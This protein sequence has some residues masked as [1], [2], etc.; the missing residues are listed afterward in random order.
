MPA[1][2]AIAAHPDDIEFVMAGTLLCLRK[3]GW[4]IHYFNISNGDLGS[5]ELKPPLTAKV[6]AAEARAAARIL[7]A[8][9]YPPICRDLSI[10]YTEEN[11]RR[12][13]SVIRTARPAIILTHALS[14]YME[15]HM[16][17][18]RLTV[19]AAFARGIPHY[20][21]KPAR[22]PVL[23]PCVVYHAMPHGQQTPM[24][25]PVR[26]ELYVNTTAVHA[27]KREALLCHQSQRQ[28]LIETQSMQDY[29]STMEQFSR[30]LGNATKRFTHA[31]GWRRHLHYGFARENDD[32]LRTALGD[33][34]IPA[35]SL[36]RSRP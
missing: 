9:W 15:D 27:T 23:D 17:A 26:P 13:C 32:P 12:V 28:W 14:D 5:T 11:L 36:R 21:S 6:R 34:C 8:K 22:Q 35:A 2:L 20:R 25:E 31:E 7:D 16:I 33:R 18:A 1:A 3:E 29:I 4:D 24:R 10:F 19:T 30:R